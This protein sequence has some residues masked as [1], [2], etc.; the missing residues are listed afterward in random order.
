MNSFR[1]L[2]N[3][4]ARS[5]VAK[6]SWKRLRGELAVK[7]ILTVGAFGLAG[8]LVTGAF[9]EDFHNPDLGGI[10]AVLGGYLGYRLFKTARILLGL[11]SKPMFQSSDQDPISEME[12]EADQSP[13]DYIPATG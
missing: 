6:H 11:N 13:P 7:G 2:A 8:A 3:L 1:E 5:A 12:S 10:A 9:G 4:S